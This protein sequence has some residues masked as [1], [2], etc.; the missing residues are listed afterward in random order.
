MINKEFSKKCLTIREKIYI[1]FEVSIFM[2]G[3]KTADWG[4]N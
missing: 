1:I 4:R 3:I 2:I